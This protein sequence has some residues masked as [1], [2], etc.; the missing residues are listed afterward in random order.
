MK[1]RWS[2]NISLAKKKSGICSTL[3]ALCDFKIFKNSWFFHT[4]KKRQSIPNIQLTI[5]LICLPPEFLPVSG[6][7]TW[8][9]ASTLGAA[10]LCSSRAGIDLGLIYPWNQGFIDIREIVLL[11]SWECTYEN[12]L[13]I[14]ERILG[15]QSY[16]FGVFLPLNNQ[17][18]QLYY[19]SLFNKLFHY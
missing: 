17:S 9:C 3:H 16:S 14:R 19:M 12:T 7:L 15:I 1:E 10:L 13:K 6:P 4:I 2:T 11:I 5:F 18:A 8:W